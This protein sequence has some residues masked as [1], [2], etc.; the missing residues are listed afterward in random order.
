MRNLL[1]LGGIGIL[2]TDDRQVLDGETS[3]SQPIL[4][5]SFSFLL[6]RLEADFD[7][8]LCANRSWELATRTT[9]GTK[10]L[11]RSATFPTKT[12][13]PVPAASTLPSSQTSADWPTATCSA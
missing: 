9:T 3:V 7:G 4:R 11:L 2:S 12:T 5:R 1:I 10:P 13:F 6:F 8:N